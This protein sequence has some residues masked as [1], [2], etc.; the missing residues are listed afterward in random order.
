MTANALNVKAAIA[1]GLGAGLSLAWFAPPGTALPTTPTAALNA[2]FLD[3]GLANQ[4]GLEEDDAVSTTPV[5][6]FGT[7]QPIRKLTTSEDRT[8]KLTMLETNPTSLSVYFKKALA[9]IVPGVG[10]GI[11]SIQ[12]GL[13]VPQRYAAVFDMLD[14][15]DH[16]RLVCPSV[17]VTDKDPIINSPLGVSQYGVTLT[18]YPDGSNVSVYRYYQ[19]AS[20]G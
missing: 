8:F 9:S 16:I 17:E 14:G 3:S 13:L 6:A 5:P 15:A 20:L 12:E 10:T 18:A 2:A 4:S 19:V 7:L 11:F 1:A